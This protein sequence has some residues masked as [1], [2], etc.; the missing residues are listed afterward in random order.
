MSFEKLT[1][2]G[3]PYFGHELEKFENLTSDPLPY[4]EAYDL[5]QRLKPI[6]VC[7]IS[8]YIVN[9]VTKLY[10]NALTAC[11]EVKGRCLQESEDMSEINAQIN[12]LIVEKYQFQKNVQDLT[13]II[14]P[15]ETNIIQYQNQDVRITL[16]IQDIDKIGNIEL[17]AIMA[18][19]RP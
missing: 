9:L 13:N 6:C 16:D 15:N 19:Y 2:H 1:Y 3:T 5:I 11:H 8:D 14:G 18:K 4:P 10:N 17:L 12:E 7:P